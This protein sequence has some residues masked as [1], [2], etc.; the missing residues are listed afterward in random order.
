MSVTRTLKYV[1]LLLLVTATAADAQ[2]AVRSG[3]SLYA[4]ALVSDVGEPS[5][6]VSAHV[7]H[8]NLVFLRSDDGFQSEYRLYIKI[9]D[10]KGKKVID[11]A[12]V[13]KTVTVVEYKHTRS[14][15][16]SSTSSHH[17]QLPPGDYIVR[18]TLHVKDTHRAYNREEKVTIA[19]IGETGIGL[20]KPRMFSAPVDT[21]PAVLRRAGTAE[22]FYVEQADQ[23][24]FAEH[25]KQP[26]FQFDVFLEKGTDGAQCDLYYEVVGENDTQVL[27]GRRSFTLERSEQQFVVSFGVDDW[28]P[29]RYQL[30]IKGSLVGA[31]RS[32]VTTLSFGLAFTRSL[33]T[34][35]FDMTLEILAYIADPSELAALRGAAE[36]ERPALWE[37]FWKRRDP[38]PNEPG[39]TALDEHWRRV[40]HAS[41]KFATGQPGWR[42]D[43]GK[44]YI[45]HG[46][47]DEVEIRSDPY[48]QGE[49][50]IWRYFDESLTFVF[51][52]RFGLGEYRLSNTRTF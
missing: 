22:R 48:Q 50:L 16:Q 35:H 38:H 26:A 8:S 39:N 18:A 42:T 17:F 51:F 25:D 2:R 44:V 5:L 21:L 10:R 3:F 34:R 30:N 13:R 31:E 45:R 14:H 7:P 32:S 52:D 49:Y 15:K 41:Q 36:S 43:R 12:V 27:Y 23:P 37:E 40:R 28:D 11:T 19:N 24:V 6:R 47:P 20:S 1:L 46:E 9:L 4:R 29:G 33:L